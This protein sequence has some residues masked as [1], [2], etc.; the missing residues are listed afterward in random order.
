MP[1][2]RARSSEYLH[3]LVQVRS[4]R[5]KHVVTRNEGFYPHTLPKTLSSR[6]Q[7][8]MTLTRIHQYQDYSVLSRMFGTSASTVS[9]VIGVCLPLLAEFLRG[10]VPN[11]FAEHPKTSSLSNQII[12]IVDGTIH[13]TVRPSYDQSEMWNGHYKMHG[14]M[15]HILCDYTGF[16]IAF[17][18]NVKGKHHDSLV[19]TYSTDFRRIL[20]RKYVLGDPG[21]SGVSHVV[22]G[23]KSSLLPKTPEH[24]MYDRVT[25]E[26]QRPIEHINC[27]LKQ[28]ST[29]NKITKFRHP[30]SYLIMCVFIVCGLYNYR[31]SRGLAFQ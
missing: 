19:S 21:Y 24:R 1:R 7:I 15:S 17:L 14:I 20:G 13:R 12:G 31:K 4:G 26:E 9:K 30:V 27:W 2:K 10:Q 16:I 29:L 3:E 18:T 22:S 8:L 6:N 5:L 11:K 28:S 23:Y 25:R